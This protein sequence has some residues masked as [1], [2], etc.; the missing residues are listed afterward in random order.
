MSSGSIHGTYAPGDNTH[1][2]TV[3]SYDPESDVTLLAL[4]KLEAAGIP[5][6]AQLESKLREFKKS[7]NIAELCAYRYGSNC[8]IVEIY[9]N[10]W[11]EGSKSGCTTWKMFLEILRDIGLQD[12]ADKIHDYLSSTVPCPAITKQGKYIILL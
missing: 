12:V 6:L 2:H 1:T 11:L 9:I 10:S 5:I 3:K 4:R 7:A 8:P